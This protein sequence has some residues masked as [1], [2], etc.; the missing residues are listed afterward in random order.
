MARIGPPR[1]NRGGAFEVWTVRLLLPALVAASLLTLA[2]VAGYRLG[3]I[4]ALWDGPERG[5]W[6][7]VEINGQYVRPHGYVLRFEHG[8]I[9]GGHD[10]CNSWGFTGDVDPRSGKR[11]ISSDAQA[12]AEGPADRGYWAI[13][14]EP[15]SFKLQDDGRLKI[16]SE[17]NALLYDSGIFW[18]REALRGTVDWPVDE[19]EIPPQPM[20]PPPPPVG[21]DA[22]PPPPTHPT[23]PP[24]PTGQ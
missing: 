4:T 13:A 6:Q 11:M 17:P 18:R 24:P 2:S 12:C 7:A 20:P 15:T 8:E 23:P 5:D 3:D 1:P 14:S 16:V 19:S 21:A 9:V 22:P 10:G